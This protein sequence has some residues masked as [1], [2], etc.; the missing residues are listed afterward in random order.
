MT[1]PPS[2]STTTQN[3]L[4]TAQVDGLAL[5][6]LSNR[7]EYEFEFQYTDNPMWVRADISIAVAY[8]TMLTGLLLNKAV[9]KV[10]LFTI[11]E[12]EESVSFIYD[13]G[14]AKSGNQP[15]SLSHR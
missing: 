13:I 12:G 2:Q 1:Y 10:K 7:I 9:S 4:P 14:A 15:W 8:K 11:T 3:N 6:Q 5:S